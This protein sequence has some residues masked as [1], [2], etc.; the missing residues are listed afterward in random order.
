MY[1]YI[2]PGYSFIQRSIVIAG[3]PCRLFIFSFLEENSSPPICSLTASETEIHFSLSSLLHLF[4]LW[5]ALF[6]CEVN[7]DTFETQL[8]WLGSKCKFISYQCNKVDTFNLHCLKV[9]FKNSELGIYG[10]SWLLH[11]E[12]HSELTEC[13]LWTLHRFFYTYIIKLDKILSLE[14]EKHNVIKVYIQF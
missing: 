6:C 2:C 9:M 14:Q 4:S 8:I 13:V 5:R 11:M 12:K 7:K 3:K 10:A 1:W